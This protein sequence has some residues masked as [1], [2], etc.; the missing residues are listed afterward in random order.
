MVCSLYL[1][2]PHYKLCTPCRIQTHNYFRR[3]D[4][5][6]GAVIQL[7]FNGAFIYCWAGESRTHD[8][9]CVRQTLLN[10]LSYSPIYLLGYW[11]SNSELL[12]QR[13]MCWP[14]THIPQLNPV[15]WDWRLTILAFSGDCSCFWTANFLIQRTS[16]PPRYKA[17][18][19][20]LA[21]I[22]YHSTSLHI[23]PDISRW[24]IPTGVGI[25]RF[26]L[27]RIIFNARF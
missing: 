23:G 17:Y 10:Q 11:D 20:L 6:S 5:Y 7:R 4:P 24:V 21:H 25:E 12:L 2:M 19:P 8:L 1:R 18:H 16:N 15:F 22:E 26:E 9:L 27:S 14:I 3:P 13:Q